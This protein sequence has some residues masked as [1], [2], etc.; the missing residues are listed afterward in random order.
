MVEYCS[1]CRSQSAGGGGVPALPAQAMVNPCG[2]LNVKPPLASFA[3]TTHSRSGVFGGWPQKRAP[4]GEAKL[5]LG[6]DQY[7]PAPR[8]VHGLETV[9]FVCAG[10]VSVKEAPVG[11]LETVRQ[12]PVGLPL[13]SRI[14]SPS[15][16]TYIPCVRSPAA[17]AVAA[18][19][20]T[21]PKTNSCFFTDLPLFGASGPQLARP[22]AWR[23]IYALPSH[24]AS[25]PRPGTSNPGP[26]KGNQRGSGSSKGSWAPA[27][28]ARGVARG[29]AVPLDPGDVG[30]SSRVH[31]LRALVVRAQ[32]LEDGPG[33]SEGVSGRR[34]R[35]LARSLALGIAAAHRHPA[36]AWEVGACQADRPSSTRTILPVTPPFAS[37][38]CARLAST[39]GKRCA[40]SGLIF[41]CRSRSSRAIKSARKKSG[42]NRLS[43]WML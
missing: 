31:T 21:T 40:T 20:Q 10:S 28:R 42:F 34:G 9:T 19:V 41:F 22:L 24:R 33:I 8:L 2:A 17:R 11:G 6:H 5:T 1:G 14:S 3:F 43:V 4:P 12:S 7:A 29:L 38:S 35:D 27:H 26:G 30:A 13:G 23:G 37:T 15:P 25:G 32:V 36:K 18:I 39:R 16:Q